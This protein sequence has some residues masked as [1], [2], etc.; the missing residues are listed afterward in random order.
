MK[1][2]CLSL[3]MVVFVGLFDLVGALTAIDKGYGRSQGS[4]RR[5]DHQ[6]ILWVTLRRGVVPL[7][8]CPV[9]PRFPP[10]WTSRRGGRLR[11]TNPASCRSFELSEVPTARPAVQSITNLRRALPAIQV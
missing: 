2:V 9:R 11:Q 7:G 10:T 8:R 6:G 1:T 3:S 4:R 5:W